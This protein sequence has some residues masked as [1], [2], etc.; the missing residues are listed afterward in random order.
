M[1]RQLQT[2]IR[3]LQ[4]VILWKGGGREGEEGVP[5]VFCRSPM[6]RGW[7]HIGQAD[8]S[9]S[10]AAIS[11]YR[12]GNWQQ[13]RRHQSSVVMWQPVATQYGMTLPQLEHC[14][15]KGTRM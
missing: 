7:L 14:A 4:R 15:H 6:L 9:C 10:R 13:G 8:S 12:V 1:T 11:E 2:N 3:K 5:T